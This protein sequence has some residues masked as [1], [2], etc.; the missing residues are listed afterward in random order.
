M[1][2]CDGVTRI[3][4]GNGDGRYAQTRIKGLSVAALYLNDAAGHW[5]AVYVGPRGGA[6]VV[7]E[8][9]NFRVL[10]DGEEQT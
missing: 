9:D 4:S 10:P 2:V 6:L 7:N 3:Y 8:I 1:L 5:A